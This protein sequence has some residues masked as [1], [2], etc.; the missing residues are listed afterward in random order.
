MSSQDHQAA[1]ATIFIHLD[2]A[3]VFIHSFNLSIPI[4]ILF[5]MCFIVASSNVDTSSS[6]R[7][8]KMS[9]IQRPDLQSGQTRTAYKTSLQSP[10]C[11]G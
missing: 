9:L 6:L 10:S 1:F 3:S 11:Q 4:F 7:T 5:T 8:N 2:L